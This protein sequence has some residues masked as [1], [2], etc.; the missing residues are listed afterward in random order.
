VTGWSD[1]LPRLGRVELVIEPRRYDDPVVQQLVAAVQAEYVVRYGGPDE[2]HVEPGEFDP[3][4]GL[5]VVGLLDGE[6]V[7]TGG[8]R[9]MDFAGDGTAAEIKRMFVLDAARRRGIAR[10]VLAELEATAVAAGIERIV[11]NTGV[12]QPEAIALY[13]SNGYLPVPGYGYYAG[14]P[15]ALFYGKSLGV[16]RIATR[17]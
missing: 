9:R 10:L 17:E 15:N 11:L 6:P 1:T 4:Q 14:Y 2:T 7:A 8:W 16:R 3:P 12:H 5:F 13:E